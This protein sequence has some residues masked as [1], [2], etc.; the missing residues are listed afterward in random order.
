LTVTFYC[1]LAENIIKNN[2]VIIRNFIIIFT[3]YERE[4]VH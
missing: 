2:R 3:L 4:D 1:K